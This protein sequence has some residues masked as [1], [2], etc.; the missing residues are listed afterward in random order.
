MKKKDKIEKVSTEQKPQPTA[1]EAAKTSLKRLRLTGLIM[2]LL[3]ALFFA[4]CAFGGDNFLSVFLEGLFGVFGYVIWLTLMALGVFFALGRRIKLNVWY[5]INYILL[6]YFLACFIH[7]V[8]SSSQ[9]GGGY[10]GSCYDVSQ[11][12]SFGGVFCAWFVYIIYL[13]CGRLGVYFVLGALLVTTVFFACMHLTR[14]F[15]TTSVD[16]GAKLTGS[17]CANA[18]NDI[19]ADEKPKAKIKVEAAKPKKASEIIQK[20]KNRLHI[21]NI[22]E[23]EE[24]GLSTGYFGRSKKERGDELGIYNSRISKNRVIPDKVEYGRSKIGIVQNYRDLSAREKQEK[25]NNRNIFTASSGSYTTEYQSSELNPPTYESNVFADVNAAQ[26]HDEGVDELRF[27]DE[28]K[29]ST[30]RTAKSVASE[31]SNAKSKEYEAVGFAAKQRADGN[32]QMV[33]DDVASPIFVPRRTRR[34]P[35]NPPPMNLLSKPVDEGAENDLSAVGEKLQRALN[36]YG[37]GARVVNAIDGPT[38]ALYEIELDRGVYYSKVNQLKTDIARYVCA[39]QPIVLVPNIPGKNLIGI[40]VPLSKFKNVYLRTVLESRNFRAEGGLRFGLGVGVGGTVVVPNLVKMPHLLV[41]GT[42][43]KGK[44]VCLNSIITSFLYRYGPEELRLILVDAKK[45]ELN[46]YNGIPHMLMPEIVTS[47]EKAVKTL[48]WLVEEM[49]RRYNIFVRAN[50]ASIDEYNKLV[51]KEKYYPMYRIVLIVDELNDLMSAYKQEIEKQIVRL[52]QMARG[53]GIHL[54][55]T[56]QRPSVDVIT[57]VI[58]GNLPSRIA[59]GVASDADSRTIINTSGAEKLCRSGD[60]I[61]LVDGVKTRLQCA[62]VDKEEV[63]SVIGYIIAHNVADV[64]ASIEKQI[65]TTDINEENGKNTK[66]ESESEEKVDDLFYDAIKYAVDK[67]EVSASKLLG[68]FSIGFSR[69]TKLM[70]L[71]EREK[72]TGGKIAPSRGNSVVLTKDEYNERYAQ[73]AGRLD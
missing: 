9:L 48:A 73:Y 62:Y 41:A 1:E 40:E 72:I 30:E 6:V 66:K 64:D 25:Y 47:A 70:Q 59:L 52:C 68:A 5:L 61:L 4:C 8:F 65:S 36:D 42:T 39:S 2:F 20:P 17:S 14:F 22:E 23:G 26:G 7:T 28:E 3:S 43:G 46:F 54:I 58:K 53:A 15:T 12:T 13:L 44:S 57:G 51:D 55:L 69:A 71:L 49:Q 16:E 50:V 35:Y 27:G 34:V 33:I 19:A 21:E 37:V 60:L 11:S 24:G 10:I 29:E 45:V 63:K 31:V 67:G 38:V 18:E 32:A 56:T